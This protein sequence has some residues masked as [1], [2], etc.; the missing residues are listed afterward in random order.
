MRVR[1]KF[2]VDLSLDNLFDTPT[3]AAF[4]QEVEKAMKSGKDNQT[5]VISAVSR[6][7]YR[8]N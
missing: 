5:T 6:D 7:K 4:T 2:N 1:K 3:I 8:V